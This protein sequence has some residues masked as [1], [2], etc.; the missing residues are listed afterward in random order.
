MGHE[1]RDGRNDQK[2]LDA[3]LCDEP[4]P[5][6]RRP[7]D[8]PERP[9]LTRESIGILDRL[10]RPEDIGIEF[11]SGRSTAWFAQRVKRLRSVEHNPVWHARVARQLASGEIGNV[12]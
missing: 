8:A 12:E 5:R 4:L 3:S 2:A 10:L 9:W 6:N 1:L 11:G 7:E